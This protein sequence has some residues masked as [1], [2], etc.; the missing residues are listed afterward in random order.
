M[1]I[2][3]ISPKL[4]FEYPLRLISPLLIPLKPIDLKYIHWPDMTWNIPWRQK[5]FMPSLRKIRPRGSGSMADQKDYATKED[6]KN[7]KEDMK[8]DLKEFKEEIIHRFHIISEDTRTQI[9]QLA[10]GITNLYEKSERD[11]AE[12]KNEI[13]E[14]GDILSVAINNVNDRTQKMDQGLRQEI[15]ETR[16]EI[17]A[18]VKFSY[19]EL[20]RRLTTLENE[21]LEL[22]RRVE[23]I[24]SRSIS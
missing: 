23:K 16:Q 17:L 8:T 11:K 1:Q 5:M 4:Y 2:M 9:K 10:E 20:D 22:K 13:K 7:L 19:A 6:L 12:L 24:E 3:Q 21:F 14:K 15:R 18:A